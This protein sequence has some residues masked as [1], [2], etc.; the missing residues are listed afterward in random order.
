MNAAALID[1]LN[2]AGVR[3]TIA[4]AKLRVVAPRGTYTAEMRARLVEHKAAVLPLVAMRDRLQDAARSIGVPGCIVDALPASELQAC[5][6]QL[7]LWEGRTDEQGDPLS[8]QV[9][10]FYLR[11]LAGQEPA[12]APMREVDP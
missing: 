8:A 11:A 2:S 6:D 5:I 7:P 12:T 10:L 3:L 4:G 9:L 1:S